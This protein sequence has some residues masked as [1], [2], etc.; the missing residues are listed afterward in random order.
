MIDLFF[1]VEDADEWHKLN[2][3]ANPSHYSG[4]GS[5][6]GASYLHML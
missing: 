3:K 4:L 5:I 6:L 1:G 2:I